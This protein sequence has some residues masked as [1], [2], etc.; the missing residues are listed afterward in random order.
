MPTHCFSDSDGYITLNMV[1]KLVID[2]MELDKHWNPTRHLVKLWFFEKNYNFP[3][4]TMIFQEK[5]WFMSICQVSKGVAKEIERIKRH[6]LWSG[7]TE[8]KKIHFVDWDFMCQSKNSGDLGLC[9]V[10]VKNRGLLNK[11]LWHYGNET[12]SLWRRVLCKKN[13]VDENSLLSNINNIK[14]L[15]TM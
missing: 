14:K 15:S 11:W 9:R 2:T 1:E 8:T 3:K 4:K 13:D 12:N 6:F 7:N 5:L 10:L